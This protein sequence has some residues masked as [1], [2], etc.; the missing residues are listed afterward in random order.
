[1]RLSIDRPVDR[2][3]DWD[4]PETM[5]ASRSTMPVDCSFVTIDRVVDRATLCTFV[6]TG[7][8]GGRSALLL[9]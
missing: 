7:R 1:M 2:P 3:I 5:R 6:H 8:P 9:A 4:K